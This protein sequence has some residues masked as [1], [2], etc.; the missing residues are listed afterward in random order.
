MGAYPRGAHTAAV[1]VR[2]ELLRGMLNADLIGFHIFEY[3]RHFLTCC[4]R[5]FGLEYEFQRGGFLGVEYGG[6]HVMVQVST[7]GVSPDLLQTHMRAAEMEVATQELQPLTEF[8]EAHAKTA[9][10]KKP[11]LISGVDYLDRFKGVQLKLLAWEVRS[12][13]DLPPTSRPDLPPPRLLLS[14]AGPLCRRR[15]RLCCESRRCCQSRRRRRRGPGG[16]GCCRRG[17]PPRARPGGRGPG[18]E[19][20]QLEIFL[21]YW[22]KARRPR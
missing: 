7:F 10:G 15:R 6:R 3:A 8:C 4:K 16:G 1:Q 19:H 20:G 5:M 13:A 11:V 2:D 17:E 22:K 9:A 12:P 14:V 18:L 21:S